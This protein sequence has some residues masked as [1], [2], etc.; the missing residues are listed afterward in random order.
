M[1]ASD[2]GR[3]CRSFGFLSRLS[4]I[5]VYVPSSVLDMS[6]E[7]FGW[8]WYSVGSVRGESDIGR[9]L[10]GCPLPQ[11]DKAFELENLCVGYVLLPRQIRIYVGMMD[12][13]KR[14]N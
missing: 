13:C 5:G 2:V 10:F 6:Q 4:C 11:C 12:D 7:C 9:L 3:T 8:G 14:R 1:R